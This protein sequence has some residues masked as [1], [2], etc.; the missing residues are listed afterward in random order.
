VILMT[1]LRTPELIADARELGAYDVVAKPFELR[2]LETLVGQ[3]CT[4]QQH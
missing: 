1:A 3:A 2:H 4:S